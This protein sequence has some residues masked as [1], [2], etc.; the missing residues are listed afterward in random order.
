MVVLSIGDED[1]LS[2]KLTSRSSDFLPW[3][4]NT[5]KLTRKVGRMS[6]PGLTSG[7]GDI[8]STEGDPVERSGMKKA[9]WH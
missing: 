3:L 6:H 8:D 1:T 2:F 4:G 7:L 5:L 9:R